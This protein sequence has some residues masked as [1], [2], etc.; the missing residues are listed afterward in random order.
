MEH[1]RLEYTD[2]AGMPRVVQIEASPFLIGRSTGNHL[3]VSS[4]EVSREH[5]EIVWVDERF[6]VRDRES[7]AG[8]FVNDKPVQEHVRRDDVVRVG[9]EH[10]ADVPEQ[11]DAAVRVL[12]SPALSAMAR[13]QAS[14]TLAI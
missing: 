11:L 9:A 6:V 12:R 4:A 5:A 2:S 14:Q 3:A 10:L 13:E 7:R 1:A 8:T